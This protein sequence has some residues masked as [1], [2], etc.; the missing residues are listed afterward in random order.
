MVECRICGDERTRM[1][2]NYHAMVVEDFFIVQLHKSK[3]ID[4]NSMIIV[5]L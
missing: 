5:R 2:W 1:S 3:H 4:V